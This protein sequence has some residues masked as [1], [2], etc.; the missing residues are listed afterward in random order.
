MQIFTKQYWLDSL[1][2]FKKVKSI[3]LMSILMA[4]CIVVG[5]LCSVFPIKLFNRTMS[6]IFIFWPIFAILFG[7]VPTTIIA[8]I[9]DLLMFVLF[10]TGYPMYIGYTFTQM[11]IGLINGLLFYKT[12]ISILKIFISQFIINFGIHVG[13]ESLFMADIM[14]YGF[15]AYK[16]YVIGGLIKNGLFLPIEITSIVI[17]LGALFPV[18]RIM[19]ITDESYL[20]KI[21]LIK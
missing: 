19:K 7:P 18:L 8:G 21:Y 14:N 12:K 3:A 2:N 6:L 16:V 5:G 20:D 13:I 1:R 17:V 15:E 10:P 4:A 11:L 9:V